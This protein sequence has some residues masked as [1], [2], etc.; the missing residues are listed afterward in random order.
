ML[1]PEEEAIK[2]REEEYRDNTSFRIIKISKLLFFFI[3]AYHFTD[4][5]SDSLRRNKK[6]N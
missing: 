4:D 6:G 3:I 2:E 1:R 5:Y